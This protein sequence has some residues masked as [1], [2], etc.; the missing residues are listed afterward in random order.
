MNFARI[1][2]IMAL[3]FPSL[4]VALQKAVAFKEPI[5]PTLAFKMAVSSLMFSAIYALADLSSGN[6][7]KESL[8]NALKDGL[9]T[10]AIMSCSLVACDEIPY[11]VP[12]AIWVATVGV[13][14]AILVINNF[15]LKRAMGLTSA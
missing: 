12:G 2:L 3:V 1:L 7:S 6:C 10:G 14:P 9:I 11:T 13:A 8:K 4:N 15:L 5:G